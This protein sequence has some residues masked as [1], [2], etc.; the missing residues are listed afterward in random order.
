MG[1]PCCGWRA[2]NVDG[3]HGSIQREQIDQVW[4]YD[5]LP[6]MASM[7]KFA[8]KRKKDDTDNGVLLQQA[9]ITKLQGNGESNSNGQHTGKN[10]NSNDG[11]F[12]L[13]LKVGVLVDYYDKV[14]R[15]RNGSGR[16]EDDL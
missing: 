13:S 10:N 5:Q 2:K 15:V 3:G 11:K 4:W 1:R 6:R 12:Q 8:L 14:V 16:L 9:G 7:D